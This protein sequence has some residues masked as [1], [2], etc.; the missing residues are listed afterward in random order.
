MQSISSR[1]GTG[2][3]PAL[4]QVWS[5]RHMFEH[6]VMVSSW[7]N[8]ISLLSQSVYLL[9]DRKHLLAEYLYTQYDKNVTVANV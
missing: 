6:E 3:K 7:L 5:K 9:P 8:I 2:S 4:E 1:K